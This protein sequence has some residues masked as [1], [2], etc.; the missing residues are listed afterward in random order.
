MIL[1]CPECQAENNIEFSGSDSEK[2][3]TECV[4]CKVQFVAALD[5]G[6]ATIFVD[7]DEVEKPEMEVE[8]PEQV[9]SD[10]DIF[11]EEP[12]DTGKNFDS[13]NIDNM[14]DQLIQ[15]EVEENK[16]LGGSSD[17]DGYSDSPIEEVPEVSGG[18]DLDNI[19]DDLLGDKGVGFDSP[20][21]DGTEVL[22][23]GIEGAPEVSGGGDL[24]DQTA[25]EVVETVEELVEEELGIVEESLDKDFQNSF[26]DEAS[27]STESVEEKEESEEDILNS[28]K[29]EMGLD[30]L[31][32]DGITDDIEESG[33]Q[34]DKGENEETDK[35]SEETSLDIKEPEESTE[36]KKPSEIDLE[37][38]EEVD[39][40]PEGSSKGDIER[41]LNEETQEI[42]DGSPENSVENREENVE[43]NP[44]IEEKLDETCEET[45]NNKEDIIEDSKEDLKTNSED[46]S[47]EEDKSEE[48]EDDLWAE[49]FAEQDGLNKDEGEGKI[50]S[51]SED[52]SGGDDSGEVDLWA[53]AFAEQDELNQ[54]QEGEKEGDEAVDAFDIA[55]DVEEQTAP[56]EDL[57]AMAVAEEAAAGGEDADDAGGIRED[58]YEDYEDENGDYVDYE[59][60]D[61]PRRKIGPIPIPSSTLGKALMGASFFAVV[62]TAAGLFFGVQ[63][64][65]PEELAKYVPFLKKDFP[66]EEADSPKNGEG[67]DVPEVDLNQTEEADL[68]AL[69]LA[70]EGEK[71]ESEASTESS[72][73]DQP[74]NTS[75]AMNKTEVAEEAKEIEKTSPEQNGFK[76]FPMVAES[77]K[78]PS[79][80]ELAEQPKEK[81]KPLIIGSEEKPSEAKEASKALQA[82]LGYKGEATADPDA[83]LLAA[84]SPS[85]KSVMLGTIMPVAYNINDIRVL[86]FDLQVELDNN[87]TA[88]LVREALPVY[89]K[90]MVETVEMFL[91]KKFYNDVLYVKE[92]LQKKLKQ[93]F[94]KSLK[95]GKVK[96][97]KFK[98]FTIQ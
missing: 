2:L 21:E 28:L 54:G 84:L 47:V 17:I 62:I 98:E 59:D 57:A 4:E 41:I 88:K 58:D 37:V 60:E 30:D 76:N 52:S 15:T 55:E 25:G 38:K 87:K 83:G 69:S 22:E 12:D 89:E 65:A 13:D 46:Q 71:S 33:T 94:N 29:E 82:A 95:G 80:K 27:E 48:S 34:E 6:E 72:S 23:E 39:S 16:S 53:Q 63:T 49:A 56:E 42:V 73:E 50:E 24:L 92:K 86:S 1:N 85:N 31:F 32:G 70:I 77:S 61:E 96:K 67:K 19:L 26:V 20:I 81:E 8:T 45:V 97:A 91:E 75:E 64:F 78:N 36:G 93:N 90:I 14:L 40:V 43:E 66:V 44:T 35:T 11:E 5:E 51:S 68:G 10:L 7:Q 9:D 18:D 79:I 74:E 3:N